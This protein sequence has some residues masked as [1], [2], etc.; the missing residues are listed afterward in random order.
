ME[1]SSPK[2]RDI[3]VKIPTHV[4]YGIGDAVIKALLGTFDKEDD[5]IWKS[6]GFKHTSDV[7]SDEKVTVFDRDVIRNKIQDTKPDESSEDE[8]EE[9]DDYDDDDYEE[10]TE[11]C[12]DIL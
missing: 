8:E 10:K 3:V 5:E 11:N 1:E 4:S 6:L 12:V 9:D 2:R 7:V